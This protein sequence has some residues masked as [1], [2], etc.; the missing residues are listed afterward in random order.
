MLCLVDSCVFIMCLYLEIAL[1]YSFF[2]PI[3]LPFFFRFGRRVPF[4]VF[5]I[6]GGV[7]CLLVLIVPKGMLLTY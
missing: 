3:T 7:A 1:F 4:C 2:F 5:M 6:I